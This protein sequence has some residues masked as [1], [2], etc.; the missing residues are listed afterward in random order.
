MADLALAAPPATSKRLAVFLD[1]TTDKSEGNTNVWRARS[2]CAAKSQDGK[3]QRIFYSPGVGT[4]LGEIVRGEV[5]G[6]GIDDVVV[7]AYEWLVENY[8]DQD[9]IFVFG[10]SRGAYTARALAGFISRC[11]LIQPGSPLAVKQLYDRYRRTDESGPLTIH[12]LR[13]PQRDRSAF[14]LEEK[15]MV[16]DCLP[17]VIK[18]I[19]V[20]DTVGP[21]AMTAQFHIV[22]GGNH[23]FLDTNLRKSEQ[24][25]YHAI[26][27]DEFRID[28]NTTMLTRYVPIT[29]QGPYNSPRPLADVEQRWFCGAHGDVGGGSYSDALAQVPLKWICAKASVHGLAFRRAIDLDPEASTG[30][31]EDS[32]SDFLNGSYKMLRLGQRN[33]REIDRPAETLAHSKVRTVNETIDKSVFDRCR[34]D[35]SYRPENL[36]DWAARHNSDSK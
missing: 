27:I 35:P 20:W 25:I 11:G 3:E 23:A 33:Y 31:I 10:F 18:F 17:I 26:A 2:L 29:E 1:G 24:H 34:R 15:W 8:E 22:T 28:F 7:S 14:S 4:Q 12:E 32:F 13:E 21:V 9:E 19:G 5:F 30:A 16:R 6:L 36:V